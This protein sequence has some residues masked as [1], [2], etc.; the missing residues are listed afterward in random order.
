MKRIDECEAAGAS[1]NFPEERP[2]FT[3]L[4]SENAFKQASDRESSYSMLRFMTIATLISVSFFRVSDAS[5][6]CQVP[7]GVYG[8]ERRFEQMLEDAATIS[9]A[10]A[11]LKE[12]AGKTDVL[13]RNQAIRWVMT[14]ETHASHTQKIVAEY[15][16]TQ[17][18]KPTGDR[19]VAKLKAAHAVMIAAMKCKQTVDPAMAKALEKS[20]FDLYRAYEGKEPDFD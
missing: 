11:Q 5:A 15:F 7:C 18:I 16:L 14:K 10:I 2:T 4:G 17:R 20:I 3:E 13:S 12:T 1:S 9:K 6:H 19:Y 8:D